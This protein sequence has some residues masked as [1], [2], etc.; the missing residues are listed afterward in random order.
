MPGA[1]RVPPGTEDFQ[2]GYRHGCVSGYSV[3]YRPRHEMSYRRDE[4]SYAADA[5]YREGW[6]K[7]FVACYEEETRFPHGDSGNRMN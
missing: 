4:K 1:D 7:G 5:E 6:Q 2:T 3:A